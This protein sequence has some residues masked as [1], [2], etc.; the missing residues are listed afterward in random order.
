MAALS[1]HDK[2]QIENVLKDLHAALE[3]AQSG[4]PG[5]AVGKV[6]SLLRRI[7]HYEAQITSAQPEP[8]AS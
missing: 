1:D 5:A 3:R 2:G 7:A 8:T 6:P 4:K